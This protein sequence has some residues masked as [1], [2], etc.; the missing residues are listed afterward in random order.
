MRCKIKTT[1]IIVLFFVCAGHLAANQF[2]DGIYLIAN[3][4][5]SSEITTQSGNK[6][7]VGDKISLKIKESRLISTNNQNTDFNLYLTL[8][9]NKKISDFS[10]IIIV[11]NKAF[12]QTSSGSSAGISSSISFNIVGE[13]NAKKVAQYFK[14]LVNSRKHPQHNL[15]ISF[16]PIKKYYFIGDI[17]FA[18]LRIVNVGANTISFD[19]GGRNRAARDNQYI[20]S[21]QYGG[22]Q[23]KDIGS[24]N[25]FGGLSNRIKLKPKGVFEDKINISKWFKFN[26]VGAYEIH[27]SYYLRFNNPNEKFSRTIWE[28][29]VTA[30]F[31]VFTRDSK[32]NLRK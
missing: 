3:E 30:D 4:K 7:F 11:N 23:V 6:I 12:Q 32:L 5:S 15:L 29:Y 19:K 13:I 2:K 24:N 9:F 14:I 21:A 16:T 27:G 20:F 26:K 18:K 25:H 22:K 17:V 31:I 8:P 10:H 28:D 1:I